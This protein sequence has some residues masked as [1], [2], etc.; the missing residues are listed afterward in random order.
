M[1]FVCMYIHMMGRPSDIIKFCFLIVMSLS[2]WGGGGADSGLE[3]FGI[4]VPPPTM[5]SILHISIQSSVM[6]YL[7]GYIAGVSSS[8]ENG[9][10]GV[11]M[12]LTTTAS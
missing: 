12:R 1:Y 2:T 9:T 5:Y 8:S 3:S 10:L 4:G 6:L 7:V 11:E